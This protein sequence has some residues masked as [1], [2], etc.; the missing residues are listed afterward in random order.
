[1]KR[2]VIG[3]ALL[4]LFAAQLGVPANVSGGTTRTFTNPTSIYLNGFADASPYPTS[5][6]VSGLSKNVTK[7]T[8][9][10][11]NVTHGEPE[12]FFALVEG[13][14]GIPVLF[15]QAEGGRNPVSG[16]TVTFDDTSSKTLRYGDTLASGSYHTDRGSK[17]LNS[18][19]AFHNPNPPAPQCHYEPDGTIV[20]P[21]KIEFSAFKDRNPN[22]TWKLWMWSDYSSGSI[23]GWSLN[24][25]TKG[26]DGGG[27]GGDCA[28]AGSMTAADC[29]PTYWT[30]FFTFDQEGIQSKPDVPA[31]SDLVRTKTEGSGAIRFNKKPKPESRT[32]GAFTQFNV[33]QLD[34]FLDPTFGET[35]QQTTYS[36]HEFL[37]KG[38]IM[39][40]SDRADTLLTS[41]QIEAHD[42]SYQNDDCDTGSSIHL[43]V[44]DKRNGVDQFAFKD[45]ESCYL[46]RVFS[47]REGHPV[48]VQIGPPEPHFD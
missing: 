2:I 43:T 31:S 37:P 14:T 24:I 22:G 46:Q 18:S 5:I 15:K 30:V 23:G 11:H 34:Y 26:D 3:V 19:G 21:Y 8:L 44:K 41:T 17:C 36:F 7:V 38:V 39:V 33:T 6:D 47:H 12:Y 16:V 48:N 1:M 13:P 27:G 10:L 42:D 32:A 28:T 9:T 35:V 40:R 29:P 25:T 20:D 45:Y 4:A